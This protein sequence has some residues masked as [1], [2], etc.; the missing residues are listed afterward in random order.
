M[1]NHFNQNYDGGS[2]NIPENVGDRFY[3]QDL[4]RDFWFNYNEVGKSIK[5]IFQAYPILLDDAAVVQGSSYHEIDIPISKGWCNYEVRVPDS[6]SS[7]PPT[8]KL[9]DII[10]KVES[11]ALTDFDIQSTATLDGVTTN[12]VKLRYKETD[13]NS[14]T[15]AKKSGTYVYEKIPSYE[16]VVN[17]IS[18]T[19]YDILLATLVGDDSTFLTITNQTATEI[20]GAAGGNS[21]VA[22]A[23]ENIAKNDPVGMDFINETVSKVYKDWVFSSYQQASASGFVND[24]V[25]GRLGTTD[26]FVVFWNEMGA[27]GTDGMYVRIGHLSGSSVVWDTSAAAA[28]SLTSGY[29]GTS[30]RIIPYST[31]Q[32]CIV[33]YDNTTLMSFVGG[34]GHLSGG[35]VI[36]D[37]FEDTTVT[38]YAMFKC[39]ILEYSGDIAFV[40]EDGSSQ[41][42]M[43][44]MYDGGGGVFVLRNGSTLSNI[45]TGSASLSA[46]PNK[47]ICL[48]NSGAEL[49]I[50]AIQSNAVYGVFVQISGTTL[51]ITAAKSVIRNATCRPNFE[52]A[53]VGNDQSSV[54][55]FIMNSTANV[56]RMYFAYRSGSSLLKKVDPALTWGGAEVFGDDLGSWVGFISFGKNY[57]W[58]G[59]GTAVIARFNP[60][61]TGLNLNDM[62]Y[63]EYFNLGFAPQGIA[64][65]GDNMFIGYRYDSSFN[66]FKYIE[67][68]G[69]ASAAVSTGNPCTVLLGSTKAD[70]F[71]GLKVGD[72]YYID[73]EAQDIGRFPSET[74]IG[75]AVSSSE[76]LVK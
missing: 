41:I 73:Y 27:G 54:A 31:G 12:Y 29:Y 23:Q 45:F 8:T 56:S 72:R 18:N 64:E 61:I 66:I 10:T 15:R 63:R 44:V 21:I 36:W 59:F 51:S 57:A 42:S 19:D 33:W 40:Y 25:A 9:E 30:L 48:Y 55:I 1:L 71:S 74:E 3:S 60:K 43:E 17:S 22:N 26:K 47:S 11:V 16:I 13:G 68:I 67:G 34:L 7:I 62:I 5:E 69:I 49:F 14:R 24:C 58:F 38:S 28:S 46:L 52:C 75:T 32:F 35:S 70:G 20:K 50:C 39:D 76:L 53:S 65:I 4:G 37:I 2:P 6:F